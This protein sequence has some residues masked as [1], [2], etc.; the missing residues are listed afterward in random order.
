MGER[1]RE[2]IG[3]EKEAR[4]ITKRYVDNTTRLLERRKLHERGREG[5][6]DQAGPSTKK[7]LLY[8]TEYISRHRRKENGKSTVADKLGRKERGDKRE[9][10]QTR[11]FC[12]G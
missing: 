8:L 4:E 10:G 2:W 6:S 3:P 7:E 12:K 9:G 11:V 1:R 5:R